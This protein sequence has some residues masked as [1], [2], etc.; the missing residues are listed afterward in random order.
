LINKFLNF[1]HL[2]AANLLFTPGAF[3]L[4]ASYISP[5]VNKRLAAGK[6][7]KLRNLLIKP[8]W[9]NMPINAYVFS[10]RFD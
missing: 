8:S 1:I 5:G 6:W 10:K 3:L 7:I 2:P 4:V 9:L